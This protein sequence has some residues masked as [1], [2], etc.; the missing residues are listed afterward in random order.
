MKVGDLVR[1]QTPIDRFFTG[2]IIEIGIYVG[3]KDTK[4]LW[5]DGFVCTVAKKNLMVVNQPIYEEELE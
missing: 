5:T 4:V 1:Y 2:I 3:R